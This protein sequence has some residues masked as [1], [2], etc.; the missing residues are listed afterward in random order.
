MVT[1]GYKNV[2]ERRRY[3][4]SRALQFRNHPCFKKCNLLTY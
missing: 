3:K 1:L 4:I 2:T